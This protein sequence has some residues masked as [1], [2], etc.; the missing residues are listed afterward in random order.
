L[1]LVEVRDLVGKLLATWYLL[2][3]VPRG[4][5]A[6]TLALWYYRRW[7]IESFFKLLKSSGLELEAW[8]QERPAALARRLLV[9]CMSC[10]L[11]WELARSKHPEAPA[12]RELL[13]RLSGRQ[14]KYG[15]AFTV[16]ALLA[17]LGILLTILEALQRHSLEELQRLTQVILQQPP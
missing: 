13:V 15:I 2:S 16:P 9:A 11:V 3:N 6:T 8:Q 1:I 12:A 7:S 10:V 4:V 14:M 5:A 17:G